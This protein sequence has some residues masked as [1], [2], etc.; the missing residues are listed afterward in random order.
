MWILKLIGN[1]EI[2]EL[3]FIKK[4]NMW[5]I[6]IVAILILIKLVCHLFEITKQ[7]IDITQQKNILDNIDKNTEYKSFEL[8][9]KKE[10]EIELS[11]NIRVIQDKYRKSKTKLDIEKELYSDFYHIINK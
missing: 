6:Y 7:F 11:K 5:F 10:I 3:A 4:K 8:L 9:N 2:S 1:R